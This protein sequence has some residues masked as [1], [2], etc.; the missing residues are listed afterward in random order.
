MTAANF[1]RLARIYAA[2]ERLAFGGALERARFRFLDELRD[3]KNIL[4][5]GEGDGRCLARLV[6]LAPHARIQCVDASAAMLATAA[7]RLRGNVH[8]AAVQFTQADARQLALPTDEFDAIVTLFFLDCFTA[9][10]AGGLLAKLSL[11]ARRDCLWLYADFA[12]P[13]EGWRRW[14]ARLWLDVLYFFFRRVTR[15]SARALPEIPAMM[16]DR[17]WHHIAHDEWQAGLLRSDVWSRV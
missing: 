14:R 16:I 10:E 4:V 5:L 17:G 12:L 1:D 3:R 6:H 11:A 8:P 2:L 7:Q 15:I 13:A 9:A